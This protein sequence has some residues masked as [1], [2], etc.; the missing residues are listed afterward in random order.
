MSLANVK[1]WQTDLKTGLVVPGTTFEDHNTVQNE[2]R[3]Y[4]AYVIGTQ[5]AGGNI[6]AMD[7]LFSSDGVPTSGND[8]EDGIAH[9]TGIAS[10]DLI[11][12]TSLSV[13][14][15]NNLNYIEF[16]GFIDGLQTLT[17]NLYLGQNLISSGG[18]I[19]L[20][21][22]YASYDINTSVSAGRRFHFYWRITI[23]GAG[24]VS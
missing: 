20:D 9:G 12:D 10:L 4:L 2:L 16:Y 7:D 19:E 8:N 18:P 14:G 17:D 6:Q 5:P 1:G 21:K 15:D 13:G 24:Q 3:Y 11:F 22:E 23:L